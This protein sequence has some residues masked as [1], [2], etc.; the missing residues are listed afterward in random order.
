MR[1]TFWYYITPANMWIGRLCLIGQLVSSRPPVSALLPDWTKSSNTQATRVMWYQNVDKNVV[2]VLKLDP[3]WK[4]VYWKTLFDRAIGQFKASCFSTP[5]AIFE[6][7]FCI[8]LTFRMPRSQSRRNPGFLS[9]FK[10]YFLS[11][12]NIIL[13][14]YYAIFVSDTC[15]RP[16]SSMP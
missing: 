14:Q 16:P 12:K 15:H 7:Q 9:L 8:R 6:V 4:H 13:H 2:D 5:R 3:I 10:F 11:Q 1:R